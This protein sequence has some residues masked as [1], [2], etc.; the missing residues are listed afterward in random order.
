MYQLYCVLQY[1]KS[2]KESYCTGRDPR[3]DNGK[4]QKEGFIGDGME[5]VVAAVNSI[6]TDTIH[7]WQRD[8]TFCN[9]FGLHEFLTPIVTV[10]NV[11]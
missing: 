6:S 9:L 1:V 8:N 11:S 3:L 10:Y 7:E 5:S 4:R 2:G